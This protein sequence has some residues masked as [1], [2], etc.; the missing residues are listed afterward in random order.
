MPT[1]VIYKAGISTLRTKNRGAYFASDSFIFKNG[2]FGLIGPT[3]SYLLR[4]CSYLSRTSD[5][6]YVLY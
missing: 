3:Y 2:R 6:F 4:T 1:E 5:V